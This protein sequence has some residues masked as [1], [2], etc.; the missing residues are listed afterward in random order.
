MG[1]TRSLPHAEAPAASAPAVIHSEAPVSQPLPQGWPAERPPRPAWI[2]IDLAAIARNFERIRQD[3]P[4]GLSFLAV[5]KDDAYGHGVLP[6]ARLALRAGVRF[7]AVATLEE[8]VRL[9]ESGIRAPILL[10]GE[11][12]PMEFPWAVRYDLTCVI[13]ERALALDLARCAARA[14]KRVPVHVK[15][16]TGMNRYGVRWDEAGHMFEQILSQPSLRLEGVLSHFAQSDERDK[17]FARTQLS[18]FQEVLQMLEGRGVRPSW[19]HLC[20]TGG[21]L[22]LPEAH[23]DMVRVG[24]LPLGVYP[25]QVCRRIPDL[26][27]AMTVKARIVALQQLRPGDTVGYGMHYR[28]DRPRRIAVLPVGYG[29]GFPR[30]RNQGAVLIHGRRAPL[31]GGVAMDAFMVDVTDI[32]Q[33]RLGDEAVLLGRQGNEEITAMELAGLRHSVVYEV[34]VG[35]QPRLPRVYRSLPG[36]DNASAP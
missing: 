24:L 33:A 1:T 26:E 6:V 7:L 32:P 15:I 10:L 20:N 34:L 8:G 28:S 11:R 35:W 18:R 2:E 12:A 23:F 36:P 27:P 9:R 4:P 31:V 3:A 14:E 13:G 17:T 21:Y 29:D 30:V 25:S 5:V 16:N 19:R 22:D